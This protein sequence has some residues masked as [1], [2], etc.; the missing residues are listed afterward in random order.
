MKK[1][2]SYRLDEEK[3]LILKEI[4]QK[5]DFK[6]EG[7]A[8]T[9]LLDEYVK[10]KEEEEKMAATAELF[11]EKFS[12]RYYSFFERLRWATRTSEKNSIMLLDAINTILVNQNL[13]DCIDIDTYMSPVLATSEDIYKNKIAH[14][15]QAKDDRNA[16][17]G[18][19][20]KS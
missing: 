10:Q 14:F 1:V 11:L 16:K 20:Q 4:M 3:E 2:K 5:H 8:I 7:A 12:E 13:N 9:F 17:K 18:G 15:K 6:S 19:P